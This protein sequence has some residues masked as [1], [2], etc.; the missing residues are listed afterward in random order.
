M[1]STGVYTLVDDNGRAAG[2]EEIHEQ[3]T[4]FPPTRGGN[5]RRYKLARIVKSPKNRGR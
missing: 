2:R 3:G 4:T 5:E 1:P